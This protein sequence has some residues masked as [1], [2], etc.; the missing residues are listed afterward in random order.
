MLLSSFYNVL[1][2]DGFIS[3]GL[4]DVEVV[5]FCFPRDGSSG[6]L[7]PVRMR[8][9]VFH[10]TRILLCDKLETKGAFLKKKISDVYIYKRRSTRGG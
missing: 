2:V 6:M 3:K 5:G 1:C 4:C 10:S 9:N 8:G 7:N